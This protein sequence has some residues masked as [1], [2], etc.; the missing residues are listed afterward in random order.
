M[1]PFSKTPVMTLE[2]RHDSHVCRPGTATCRTTTYRPQR[3]SR[4]G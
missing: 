3:P 2:S 1:A 4:R